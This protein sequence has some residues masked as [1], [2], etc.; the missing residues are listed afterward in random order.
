[1]RRI[2]TG[3]GERKAVYL[4]CENEAVGGRQKSSPQGGAQEKL[5]GGESKREPSNARG[6][7]PAIL[8]VLCYAT[9]LVSLD[10]LGFQE[11]QAD[12]AC[13]ISL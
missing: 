3:G 9:S 6:S 5:I 2:F 1:M 11:L 4:G 13:D 12:D 8:F 7:L 10:T